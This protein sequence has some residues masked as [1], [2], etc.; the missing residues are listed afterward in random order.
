MVLPVNIVVVHVLVFF[1][2]FVSVIIVAMIEDVVPVLKNSMHRRVPVRRFVS[3]A[4]R[5]VA[6]TMAALTVH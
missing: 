2:L 6:V 5:T 1:V 4:V 3:G